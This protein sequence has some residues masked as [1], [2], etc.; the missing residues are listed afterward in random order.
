M[1]QR[2]NISAKGPIYISQ[3]MRYL[4]S[5]SIL[6]PYKLVL[7]YIPSYNTPSPA[8]QLL[9]NTLNAH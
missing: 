9:R 8:S 3:Y 7:Y 2:A 6:L 4:T 5:A 1:G